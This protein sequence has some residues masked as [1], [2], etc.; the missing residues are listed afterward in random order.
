MRM[1]VCRVF[2]MFC[3][4]A[5]GWLGA[6]APAAAQYRPPLTDSIGEEYH[7]EFAYGW[8]NASPSLIVNSES[9]DIVGT[10]VDLVQ[11]L[12][13]EQ[14]K[15]GKINIVLRPAKKHR[16]RFER[17]PIQYEADATVG[18][19]FVFNGQTFS[20]GLPVQTEAKFDTYRFGYEY[21]F[22][23]RSKG[24][25][26]ALVELKYTN[27]DV[28]LRQSDPR[29]IHPRRGAGSDDRPR[30]PCLSNPEP[31]AQR[32]VLVVPHARE[33]GRA[34]RGARHLHRLRLQRDL[35]LQ[36]V[37]RRAGRAGARST[38]STT[39]IATTAP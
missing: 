27:I 29:G 19:I 28:E 16:F 9:L 38:S 14:K 1:S 36:P 23:Y 21:D 2:V 20:V 34:A 33:P 25:L 37:R 18:R 4:G 31:G 24:F 8:W 35:Q 10:D 17:L 22:L 12:G 26:G 11:D 5:T 3:L 13:I 39:S 7:I 30:R 6:A 15:L 32:R